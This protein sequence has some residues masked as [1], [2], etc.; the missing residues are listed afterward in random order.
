MIYGEVSRYLKF[1][2]DGTAPG[3]QEMRLFQELS[4]SIEMGILSIEMRS[5]YRDHLKKQ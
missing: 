3:F 5:P 4:D 1:H 2:T